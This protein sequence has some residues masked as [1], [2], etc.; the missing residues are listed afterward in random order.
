[1]ITSTASIAEATT[2]LAS[3]V[4]DFRY[5]DLPTAVVKRAKWVTGDT[6][7]VALRG[8]LEPE[9]EQLYPRLRTE[10]GASLLKAGLPSAAPTTAA[11]AN[12]AAASFLQLE[13]G[14]RPAGH[15]ALH[16]LPPALA[17]A[18]VDQH[19][20]KDF[21]L[22]LVL[23]YEV[24]ARL[25]WA[26]KL[27]WPVQP[28]GNFGHVAAITALGK[29]ARWSSSQLR[30][31]MTA[32][33]ATAMATSWQYSLVG[34]TIRNAYP[35]LTA[36]AV[37]TVKM[38]VESGFSGYEGAFGETFGSILGERFDS[39]AITRDLGDRWC[40]MENYFKFHASASLSQ[41]V[42]DALAFA[43]GGAPME[44]QFPPVQVHSPPDPS[45][46][47]QVYVR[48]AER[49]MHLAGQA[50][51]NQLSAK[52]S[53]PYAVAAFLVRG[54]ADLGAF[55]G[56]SLLNPI[57][58]ALAAKVVV[59]GVPDL[60][61]RWPAESVAEVNIEM[62]GGRTLTGVCINPYGSSAQP[63]S[64]SSLYTKFLSLTASVLTHREQESVWHKA[65]NL[66]KLTHMDQFLQKER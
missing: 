58:A 36:Q 3:F 54:K 66:E 31:G 23:G 24:Q 18:E 28:N 1:V 7:G 6:V 49:A 51:T 41:P 46:I 22:A 33:A 59:S 65:M 42:L 47:E 44:G 38:L 61:T 55:R 56:E 20:G 11:F 30:H 25:Q 34:A 52:F 13:E 29:L 9:M 12:A 5:E 45:M 57:I 50:E 32:A 10:K 16:V 63:P 15:P 48:V 39:D 62:Q 4:A 37:F 43:L 60:N 53:I 17:A 21:L 27:R 19:S 2:R 64:E 14:C 35:G 8:S 40:I 26:T